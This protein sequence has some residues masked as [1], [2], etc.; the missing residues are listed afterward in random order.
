MLSGKKQQAQSSFVIGILIINGSFCPFIVPRLHCLS[1]LIF[2]HLLSYSSYNTSHS[3]IR[4]WSFW[5]RSSR[6]AMEMSTTTKKPRRVRSPSI[7]VDDHFQ[8]YTV[9]TKLILI[10]SRLMSCEALGAWVQPII[11][12]CRLKTVPYTTVLCP[13]VGSA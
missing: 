10:Y 8:K 1:Q 9:N 4:V 6:T 2:I 3:T 7:G 5:P 13:E 12:L 11:E